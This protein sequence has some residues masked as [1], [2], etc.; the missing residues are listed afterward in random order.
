MPLCAASNLPL[1]IGDGAGERALDV[2]EQLALDQLFGNRRAVHF[3]ERLV[4]A[5]AQRM[6]GARDEL[7]AG[8][9]LA[10]NQHAA[11][12]RCRHRHLLAQLAH[13]QALAD[14]LAGAIDARA[15]R[16]ILGLE[17]PL[18]QR[19]AD[20]EHRLLERQRLLDEVERAHLDGLHGRFDVA[21]AGNHDDLRIDLHLPQ[22]RQRRQAVQPG[23]HTSST[24]TS[25]D[26]AHDA[27]EALFAALDGFDVV[28][29]VAQHAA[30]RGT[31]ARLVID[32]QDR[33]LLTIVLTQSRGQRNLLKNYLCVSAPLRRS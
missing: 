6:N 10:E 23:S 16:A 5:A 26:V 3:D 20:H 4:P 19:V 30:Q 12:G 8:A 15:K 32:D 17:P 14:H 13:E 1:A 28:A 24:M 11:V 9:V 31:H 18:P 7:F 2:A 33:G 21:V 29:F 22:P 25:N 27:V